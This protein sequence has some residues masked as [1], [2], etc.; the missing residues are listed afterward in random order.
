MHEQGAQ[1]DPHLDFRQ[2]EQDLAVRRLDLH[3]DPD[4]LEHPVVAEA[5]LRV[6]DRDPDPLVG[7]RER[8]LDG[9]RE[10]G[11]LDRPRREA[12]AEPR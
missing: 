9:R 7:G 12:R 2:L 3:V 8:A 10:P 5:Q 4:Q 11:Q 1:A 6:A